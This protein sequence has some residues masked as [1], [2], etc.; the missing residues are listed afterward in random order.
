VLDGP[1]ADQLGG[2]DQQP[3]PRGRHRQGRAN[4]DRPAEHAVERGI[5]GGPRARRHRVNDHAVARE[6]SP[7]HTPV[8]LRCGRQARVAQHPGDVVRPP[9][10]HDHVDVGTGQLGPA[11]EQDGILRL[12]RE[13]RQELVRALVL[14][15][16]A[17][18][19]GRASLGPR[20]G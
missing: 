7:H 12:T 20:L 19:D 13:R 10:R 8:V 5:P 17:G 14:E 4:F 1:A 11:P 18:V 6:R 15:C 3:V 2:A 16:L 9:R